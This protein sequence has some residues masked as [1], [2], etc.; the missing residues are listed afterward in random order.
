[1]T[2]P[3]RGRTALDAKETAVPD[4][5]DDTDENPQTERVDVDDPFDVPDEVEEAWEEDDVAEGEA[6]SG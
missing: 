4:P 1:M 3:A 5:A 6:P 2:P